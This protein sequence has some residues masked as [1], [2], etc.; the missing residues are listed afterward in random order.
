MKNKFENLK[1]TDSRLEV[2]QSSKKQ[3]GKNA[4]LLYVS[5]NK[6][7]TLENL[8]TESNTCSYWLR[9][10]NCQLQFQER[11]GSLFL[12]KANRCQERRQIT[13]QFAIQIYA[14]EKKENDVNTSTKEGTRL[15]DICATEEP[16]KQKFL[17]EFK[18]QNDN[19]FG[20][21]LTV[22][23]SESLNTA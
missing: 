17:P 4:W 8:E 1:T 22:S 20:R 9:Q 11:M 6:L 21:N 13:S 5:S 15:K 7:S 3:C 18:S 12:V 10:L 16:F 19:V 23:E 2:K 14:R